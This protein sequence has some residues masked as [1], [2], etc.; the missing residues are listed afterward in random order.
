M[1]AIPSLTER[2][3][4]IQR[5]LVRV[6]GCWRLLDLSECERWAS[7]QDIIL[8]ALD[9][10]EQLDLQLCW[11]DNLPADVLA[12]PVPTDDERRDTDKRAAGAR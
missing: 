4:T 1:T 5:L 9:D 7:P 10:M 8:A 6:E 2:L 11:L 3:E 12:T